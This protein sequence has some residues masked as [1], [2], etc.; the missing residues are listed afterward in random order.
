M[1]ANPVSKNGIRV[2]TVFFRD[3]FF[4]IMHFNIRYPKNTIAT[5]VTGV[6][7]KVV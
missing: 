3:K 2:L 7:K 4:L 5:I 1:G 6:F